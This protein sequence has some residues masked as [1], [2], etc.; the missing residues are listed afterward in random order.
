MAKSPKILILNGPNLNMLG[1]REPAIYGRDSLAD[2]AKM[3]ARRAKELGLTVDF[4][5][6]NLEGELVTWI[7]E[8]RKDAAGIV[9]NPA[10][11]GHT[12]VALLDALQIAELPVIEV[13]LSNIHRRESFRH[14]TYTSQAATGIICGLGAKGY[15]LALDA[16]AGLINKKER[17]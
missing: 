15:V 7:H 12:S 17:A 9:I 6:S 5:Q 3:C 14:H 11:Y 8:A 10:G 4:R 13:H 1:V 16:I 2:I